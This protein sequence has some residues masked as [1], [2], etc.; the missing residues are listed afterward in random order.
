MARALK[1]QA[2][3]ASVTAFIAASPRADEG[4][5]VLSLMK[6]ATGLTPKMWGGSIVGFGSY[7]YRYDSGQT[8]EWPLVGFSPRKGAITLYIMPGFDA[9]DGL[10][11]KLGKHSTGKSCLYIKKLADIDMDVLDELVRRSVA[12]MKAKY[13]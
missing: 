2:T 4:K 6:K 10:L 12:A 13:G 5:A 1:T 3:A 9:Y 11:K 7:T 8:G